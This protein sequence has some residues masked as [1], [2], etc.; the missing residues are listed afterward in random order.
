MTS[1]QRLRDLRAQVKYLSAA[2]LVGFLTR[3]GLRGKS[4]FFLP[5]L[6]EKPEATKVLVLSPHPDDDVIGCGGV[7]CKHTA[8]KEEVCVVHI[9]DGSRGTSTLAESQRLAQQRKAEARRAAGV[10]GVKTV[11]FFDFQDTKLGL[12]VEE[13]ARMLAELILELAPDVVYLPFPLDYNADHTATTKSASLAFELLDYECD[14][15]AYETAP[16]L[17]PNRIVDITK[18]VRLKK[19][20]LLCHRSQMSQNDYVNVVVEGLG[21][22]RTHGLLK[23]KGYAE[24]FF[25]CDVDY[26]G[27]LI[28]K[29]EEA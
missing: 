23:G 12:F 10:I 20:A 6:I 26:L 2:R 21:R 13:C 29:L 16:P 11:K 5:T 19:Q 8:A 24:A 1:L 4:Q 14:L 27:F 25:A 15:F 28:K 3:L 18:Q 17:L 7:L 22:Y 9:T